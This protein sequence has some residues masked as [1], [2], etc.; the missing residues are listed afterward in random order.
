MLIS[1]PDFA[2]SPLSPPCGSAIGSIIL[3]W[4]IGILDPHVYFSIYST[5]I[6]S[7]LV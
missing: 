6:I 2:Q 1:Q 7:T 4:G 3:G 5:M